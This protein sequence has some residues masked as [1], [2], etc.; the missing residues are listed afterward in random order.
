MIYEKIGLKMKNGFIIANEYEQFVSR[1]KVVDGLP[2]VGWSSLLSQAMVFKNQE[3]CRKVMMALIS[4]G[5]NYSLWEMAIRETKSRLYLV[6]SCEVNPP[7]FD[8]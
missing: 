6:S 7:W 5:T 2:L 3:L 8:S 4:I 1:L